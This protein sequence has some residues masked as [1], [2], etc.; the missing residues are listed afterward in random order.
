TIAAT[1]GALTITGQYDVTGT[2]YWTGSLSMNLAA[3]SNGEAVSTGTGNLAG[4]FYYKADGGGVYKSNSKRAFF[5]IPQKSITASH[6]GSKTFQGVQFN[7]TDANSVKQIKVVS[8]A[9]GTTYTIT[10]YSSVTSET[11]DNTFTDTITITNVNFPVNGMMIGTVT[12]TGTGAGGP[13]KVGC[14][15]NKH[16]TKGLRVICS[17]QSPSNSTLPYNI[18]FSQEAASE[19]ACPTNYVLVRANSTVGAN[20]DFCVAKYEMKIEG[21]DTGNQAYSSSLVG[22][23]RAAG[24]PWVNITRNQAISECQALGGAYDLISNAQWQALARD[25]EGA[26]NTDGTYANWSNGAITGSNALNRG[27]SDNSPGNALAAS[28]DNDPCAGTGNTNCATNSDSDFTQKR[29]HTLTSGE[30]IWDVAGNVWEWVK[31]NNSST[32]GVNGYLSVKTWDGNQDARETTAAKLLWGPSGTYTAKNSGEYGG[33]GWGTL[34]SSAGAVNRGGGW[35][36]HNYSG[37]F[38]VY[39]SYGPAVTYI[40]IGFRCAYLPYSASGTLAAPPNP[41]SAASTES[42]TSISL[43][44][45]SSG[46]SSSS[47]KI[48][49]EQGAT[50]PS[51]CNSGTVVTSSTTSTTISSLT[52]NTQYSFRI[53]DVNADGLMSPGITMT[54]STQAAWAGIK[55]LRASGASSSVQAVTR[56]SADNIYVAGW[57]NGTLNTVGRTGSTDAFLIKY[58]SQGVVQWTKLLGVAGAQTK[59]YGVA[60]D[61][62][63]NVYIGGTTTGAL[64]GLALPTYGP[65]YLF[66]TKYDSSGTKQWTKLDGGVVS[67]VGVTIA[68][69]NIYISGAAPFGNL[70]PDDAYLVKYNSS[71]T[72]QWL[73]NIYKQVNP[74]YGMATTS[75]GTSYVLGE[76]QYTSSPGGYF[77]AKNNAGSS[78]GSKAFARN[79]DL[80]TTNYSCVTGVDTGIA[81][82]S[83]D[84]IYVTG[85]GYTRDWYATGGYYKNSSY[86][87]FGATCLPG[88]FIMKFTG[89]TLQWALEPAVFASTSATGPYRIAIDS[90]N[91]IYVATKANTGIDGNT[92]TG[93]N[94]LVLVK[95]NSSRVKQWTRQLGAAA[96]N[97]VVQAIKIDSSGNVFVVGYT[98]GALDGSPRSGANDGFIVKYSSDGTRQ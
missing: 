20:V 32:R 79:A 97:T 71:G 16:F 52:P 4:T 89:T 73:K 61:S 58:N 40:Y 1:T 46:A 62:T 94:D 5:M 59:A 3:C 38:G 98:T 70:Y 26:V 39:L 83:A 10:P 65:T 54:V 91:N 82:D 51:D 64:D 18:T 53:C 21:N 9:A 8:N 37:V 25:I 87:A 74:A 55:Q 48:A 31:D 96:S 42:T 75:V 24:T 11:V 93:T 90:D 81:T 72:R 85:Y 19:L 36:D 80:S 22:E 86:S 6:F 56:D 7:S 23:S 69:D 28:T 66:L 35:G 45:S 13:T 84:N 17:G 12:R 77:S 15:A 34:N 49:Y 41:R 2:S 29:T 76:D 88:L 50:A 68:A 43:S 47:F 95:F 60:V 30:V 14:I 57:T 44:W 63:D 27:H 78:A 33:L 67:V 92:L